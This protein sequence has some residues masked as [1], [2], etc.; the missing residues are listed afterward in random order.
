[1]FEASFSLG[2]TTPPA[3][4]HAFGMVCFIHITINCLHRKCKMFGEF[5]T[6]GIEV[7]LVLELMLLLPSS[8]LLPPRS[9]LGDCRPVGN[10][11]EE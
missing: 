8:L 6:A 1:M 5:Y 7:H 3:L 10:L 4:R 11:V 9:T 2:I